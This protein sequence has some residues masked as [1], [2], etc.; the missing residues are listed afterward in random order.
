M[1]ID[2]LPVQLERA[3]HQGIGADNTTTI[4]MS[5]VNLA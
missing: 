3:L 4:S 1:L 2:H 5:L